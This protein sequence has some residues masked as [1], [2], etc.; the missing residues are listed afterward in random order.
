MWK[1][2]GYIECWEFER[3]FGCVACCMLRVITRYYRNAQ[4]QFLKISQI[5]KI[6]WH[7]ATCN[8]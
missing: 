2:A 3:G 4:Y 7:L 1:V 5:N 6:L 8:L